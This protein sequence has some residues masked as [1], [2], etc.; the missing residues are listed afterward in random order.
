MPARSEIEGEINQ[1][2][3]ASQDLVRRRYLKK[4][5]EKTGNDVVVY[6]SAFCSRRIGQIP[7]YLLQITMEDMQGFMAALHGLKGKR[8]DLVLHS[9]GGSLEAA[10]QV[11]QYLRA[12]YDYIKAIIP[13]NAMSAATLIACACDEICM[14]K[15]SALG[16]IDPQIT[17]PTKDGFRTAPAFDLLAEFE[18]AKGEVSADAKVSPIW[19]N[20]IRDYP[21][22]ILNTC[23]R[24]TELSKEKVKA[25]LAA[26]MFKG[27]GQ[28]VQ[29]AE[30][31]GNWLGNAAEH[32]THGRPINV[33]LAQEKGL[34]VTALEADQE[35]QDLV[36]SVFHATAVTFDHTGCVK[37]VENHEG[38]GWFISGPPS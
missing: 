10:E 4:L 34:K 30:E 12:K 32:K 28:S 11:V 5:Q 20:K 19:V 15:Q 21:P 22:G 2:R 33:G 7:P 1:L 25:W 37:F 6:A 17:F 29:K 36:L 13:Q 3:A 18:Q 38:R 35:L 31:I 16:P 26:Y 23:K 14:G 8:L 24:T 9:P 27:D